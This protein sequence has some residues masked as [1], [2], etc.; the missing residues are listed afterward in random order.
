MASGRL[1]SRPEELLGDP[2]QRRIFELMFKRSDSKRWADW[3]RAPLEQ[4]CDEGD[5]DLVETLLEA[6]ANEIAGGVGPDGRTLLH[7]GASGGS[8]RVLWALLDAGAK[9]DIDIPLSDKWSNRDTPLRLAVRRGHEAA[10]KVLASAGADL[11][12]SISIALTRGDE[13]LAY[14]LLLAGAE[15]NEPAQSFS[16]L[17]AAARRG[18]ERLVRALLQKGHPLRDCLPLHAAV[19]GGHL[20]TAKSLISAGFVVNGYDLYEGHTPLHTAVSGDEASSSS[21]SS[22]GAMID[23]L[24]AAGADVSAQ[25]CEPDGFHESPLHTAAVAGNREGALALLQHGADVHAVI[26]R[27]GNQPLHDACRGLKVEVAEVLLR[28]GADE[29]ATNHRGQTAMDIV[30]SPSGHMSN[31]A[32]RPTRE[33]LVGLLRRAPNDRAWRRRCF[34]VLCRS[35]PRNVR[36]ALAPHPAED[37]RLAS[38]AGTKSAK[39]DSGGVVGASGGRGAG[40][41]GDGGADVPGAS[42]RF[43]VL[44]AWL[45]G[46]PEEGVF[47]NIVGFL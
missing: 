7:F 28:W 4:A 26:D 30:F 33:R 46:V 32:W 45:V 27:S 44:A 38:S 9:P 1:K 6:G 20:S 39:T 15:P 2:E 23:L 12:G 8:E 34:Y 3:L 24:V 10:A 11:S 22:Q 36:L 14:D 16:N 47:R 43:G 21:S 19:R 5:A 31:E 37:G 41:G 42:S 18:L 13:K 35:H 29:T 17:E 25:L 40:R